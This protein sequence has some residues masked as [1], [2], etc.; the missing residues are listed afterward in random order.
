MPHRRAVALMVLVTLLWSMAGVVTRQLEA[1]RS[2][3]L[4]F[5]RSSFNALTLVL[6]LGA[7]RGFALGGQLLRASRAVWVSSFCWAAMFTAFMVALTLTR[8]ANVLVTMA[9]GPL[10]TALFARVFL[11]HRLPAR[12]WLAIIVGSA[13]VAW[14]F[15]DE[16]SGKGLLGM[17][18]AFV[19]PIAAATNWTL[20]QGRPAEDMPLA[21]LLGGLISAAFALPLA[22]PLQAG[23]HDLALLAVLGVFQLA[24][25]CLLLIR[26]TRTLSAPEVALLGL[27]EVVFGVLWAWLGA[28]ETP[29]TATL[30]GGVMVLGAL[31]AN[32]LLAASS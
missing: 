17:A 22:W 18:V 32:E 14:M 12:T 19:V 30:I 23:L 27:L 5:W 4:T 15:A 25:P 28:G 3:E 7:Q 24:L 29:T 8:V 13:G 10:L 1:A 9:L 16:L 31:A 6:I 11:K 26:L 2:F 20:L 21:L